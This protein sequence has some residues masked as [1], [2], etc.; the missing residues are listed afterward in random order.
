MNKNTEFIFIRHGITEL[1]E[2]KY[3]ILERNGHI[4]IIPDEN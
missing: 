2:I 4:S 1:K 3:A